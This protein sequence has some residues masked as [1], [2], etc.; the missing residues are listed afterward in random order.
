MLASFSRDTPAKPMSD[1]GCYFIDYVYGNFF[2]ELILLILFV[3]LFTDACSLYS[4]MSIHA[5]ISPNKIAK[6][7]SDSGRYV[8][9][10]MST[11]KISTA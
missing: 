8:Y 1:S 3:D 2:Y 10:I 6:P 7:I 4:L 5:G 11:E 9:I